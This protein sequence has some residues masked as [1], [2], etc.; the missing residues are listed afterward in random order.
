MAMSIVVQWTTILCSSW[1]RQKKHTFKIFIFKTMCQGN[2]LTRLTVVNGALWK[3]QINKLFW[4]SSK[5]DI[6]YII[7]E[8]LNTSTSPQK[9]ESCFTLTSWQQCKLFTNLFCSFNSTMLLTNFS[10]ITFSK[11]SLLAFQKT[12]CQHDSWRF[13]AAWNYSKAFTTSNR[14]VERRTAKSA[15]IPTVL[16]RL[17]SM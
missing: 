10:V 14:Y 4:L 5:T 16:E 2:F 11:T 12:L 8:M 6:C 17:H 13:K 15:G 3:S 1:R 7:V 9:Y